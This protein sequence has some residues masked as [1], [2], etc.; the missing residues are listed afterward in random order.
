MLPFFP[1]LT[2]GLKKDT[3]WTDGNEKDYCS[4]AIS[5][6]WLTI[7]LDGNVRLGSRLTVRKIYAKDQVALLEDL[8]LNLWRIDGGPH[9]RISSPV[10]CLIFNGN[11]RTEK[12][13]KF[14]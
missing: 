6:A 7:R 12:Q 5:N 10:N 13:M 14:P 2:N 8:D 11:I 1:N 4:G 3:A 9:K